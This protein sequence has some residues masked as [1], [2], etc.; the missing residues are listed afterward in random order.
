MI[1]I[2]ELQEEFKFAP[3]NSFNQLKEDNYL[4]SKSVFRHR[5]YSVGSITNS[6][7]N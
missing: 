2:L 3:F 5:A 4:K 7:L 1:D 6:R